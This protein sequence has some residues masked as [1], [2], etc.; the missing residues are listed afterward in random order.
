M[1]IY[2]SFDTYKKFLVCGDI[3][4]EFK[5]LLY[6]LKRKQIEDAVVLVAGDCGI[7]FEK[8]AYYEQ[9]YKKLELT[10][11][12]LN[13]MLI[14]M[15][16][17]HDNPDYF[18]N[19]LIDYPRMKTIP[20]YCV[21]QFSGNN[22]LCIGG[23]VSIDREYRETQMGLAKLKNRTVTYYWKDE[24]PVYAP[25]KLSEIKTDGLKINTVITHTAPSFCFPTTKSGIEGWLEQD[26]TL[27]AD[28][29]YEGK[30]MDEIYEHLKVDNHPL[31]TWFYAHSHASKVEYISGIRFQLLNILEL[32]QVR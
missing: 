12:K 29:D 4:G 31:S 30:V 7:G 9:L 20:D 8:P 19:R 6:E 5:T 18:E 16:G 23:A 25:E 14:L 13:C 22:I 3:H 2:N 27:S 24:I 28:L 17:N 26:N 32:M 11:V 1:I 21:I 10:L 15:R